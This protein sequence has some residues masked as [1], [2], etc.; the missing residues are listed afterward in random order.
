MIKDQLCEVC[1]KEKVKYRCPKCQIVYCSVGCYKGHKESCEEKKKDP[2]TQNQER[3]DINGSEEFELGED[4][5]EDKVPLEKLKK[6]EQSVEL[7]TMLLNPHLRK[8]IVDLAQSSTLTVDKKLEE[9]LT[10]PIFTEFSDKCI[11]VVD[12][13]PDLIDT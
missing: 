5:S 12:D 1:E 13:H 2:Q 11:A 10:E 7:R 4:E 6:L 3:A 8:M 9:A